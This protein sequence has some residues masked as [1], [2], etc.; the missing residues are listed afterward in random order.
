MINYNPD[1]I[2]IKYDHFKGKNTQDFINL[3]KVLNPDAV[4]V[5]LT[6]DGFLV[7]N[8]H[9]EYITNGIEVIERNVL[10]GPPVIFFFLFVNR[11][12]YDV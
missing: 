11:R 12:S 3:L 4:A 6:E 5:V 1:G 7:N 2:L 10:S 8:H 9:D